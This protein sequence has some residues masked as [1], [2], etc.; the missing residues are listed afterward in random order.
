[1][2]ELLRVDGVSKHFGGLKAVQDV[3]FSV[4]EGE[5]FSVIGPN[6]AGKTTLFNV[7]SAVSRASAGR[8]M[9]K[10]QELTRCRTSDLAQIGV[11]RTFQNLA[12]FHSEPTID[13]VLV[14]LH[15]TLRGTVFE[16][17]FYWGR[18]RE[19]EIRARRRVEDILRFLRLEHVRDVPVGTLAYGV[20]KRVE[21]ARAMAAQPKLLLL[22]EMVSGMNQEEREDIARF[23]LDLRDEF[24]VTVLMIEH[25]MGIIMDL[26][27]RVAVMHQGRLIACDRP[28]AIATDPQVIE[29]YLGRRR[30]A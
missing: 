27:D 1:M 14:G 25:D 16:C 23:V 13:N 24:G 21:L 3:S 10:D 18:V 17:A 7:I 28:E 19:E 20:Q 6:G 29:A 30:G 8:V 12:L 26:S 22:D 5:I 2:T 11:S 4:G 15:S 9:F